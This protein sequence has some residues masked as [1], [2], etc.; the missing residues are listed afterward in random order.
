LSVGRLLH[1]DEF[2]TR[3]I[4]GVK[5]LNDAVP[6]RRNEMQE[7][8]VSQQTKPRAAAR[9]QENQPIHPRPTYQPTE[10]NNERVN[11]NNCSSSNNNDEDFNNDQTN[12]QRTNTISNERPTATTDDYNRQRQLTTN[13]R[14]NE[15]NNTT[16]NDD[17]RQRPTTTTTTDKTNQ[18]QHQKLQIPKDQP[19][20]GRVL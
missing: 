16:T 8:K 4:D 9:R 17:N 14:A 20:F 2:V 1:N 7:K 18:P 12:N 13:E 3:D 5:T 19:N 6:L 11:C 15:H 10:S